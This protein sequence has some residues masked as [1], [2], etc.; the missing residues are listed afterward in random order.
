[1]PLLSVLDPHPVSL[2]GRA[3]VSRQAAHACSVTYV[4]G[5]SDTLVA[6]VAAVRAEEAVELAE[7]VA[8]GLWRAGA[9]HD[10]SALLPWAGVP[11]EVPR[12]PPHQA[13]AES[14]S[15]RIESPRAWLWTFPGPEKW[16]SCAYHAAAADLGLVSGPARWDHRAQYTSA[17]R[18]PTADGWS[19]GDSVAELGDSPRKRPV[20]HPVAVLRALAT[21]AR[22][23]ENH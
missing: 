23:A 21:E 14:W 18:V 9:N 1:M 7:R 12:V 22:E 2:Y 5:L 11:Y 13:P 4:N 8:W 16:Q 20:V 15:R 17:R 19:L 6:L 10:G 3:N